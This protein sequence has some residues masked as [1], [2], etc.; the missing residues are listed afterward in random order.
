M[1]TKY[2]KNLK[3]GTK[4]NERVNVHREEI[5]ITN[6]FL[7]FPAERPVNGASDCILLSLKPIR[8]FALTSVR[9]NAGPWR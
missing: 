8:F 7:V 3:Y 6:V 9:A 5:M 4:Q 1:M 2:F